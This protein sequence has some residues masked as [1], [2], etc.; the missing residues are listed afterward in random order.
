MPSS[1]SSWRL[2]SLLAARRL[3]SA[4]WVTAAL[5]VLSTPP[6]TSAV[7]STE[8]TVTAA[9]TFALTLSFTGVP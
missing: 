6:K 1:S 7:S 8:K 4:F 2:T 3:S 5:T 9:A